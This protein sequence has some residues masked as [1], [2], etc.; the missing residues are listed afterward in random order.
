[1]VR[2][3]QSGRDAYL[4]KDKRWQSDE[5]GRFVRIPSVRNDFLVILVHA[6]FT[7]EDHLYYFYRITPQVLQGVQWVM[8]VFRGYIVYEIKRSTKKFCR[9]FC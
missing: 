2:C 7:T 1:M 4:M 6:S 9:F 5:R 3:L 8:R